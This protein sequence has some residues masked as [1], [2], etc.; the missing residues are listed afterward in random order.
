MIDSFPGLDTSRPITQSDID[1]GF[2]SYEG[3]LIENFF[4]IAD[5]E[6]RDVPFILNAEQ[7]ELDYKV[8][9]RRKKGLPIKMFIPKARR[10][11]ISAYVSARFTAKALTQRNIDGAVV[12]HRQKETNKLFAKVDYYVRNFRGAKPKLGTDSTV[13]ISFPET[14][15]SL[16][17]FTA[18]SK[19]VAR[20]LDC[21]HLHL[22]EAAFYENPKSL[23]ASLVQTI[24]GTGEIFV[25]STGN[26]QGTWY[27]RRCTRAWEGKSEY[28]IV[29][30]PWHQTSDCQVSLTEEQAK[31]LKADLPN[32]EFGEAELLKMF[33]D[34]PLE[35]IQ[36][37]RNKI[38]EF[39]FDI[40][41]FKQEYPMIFEECFIPT[42]RS[43]FHKYT[44]LPTLE[45]ELIEPGLHI[46]RGHPHA[47]YHYGLG[48]DV[49]AG[50]GED[51]SVIQIICLETG[52]QVLEWVKDDVPPDELA[53]YVA[54]FG[55]MFHWPV[56]VVESNNHGI[57]TIDHLMRDRDENKERIYKP[58][59]IYRDDVTSK[60]IVGGGFRTM[61]NTKP[62]WLGKLRRVLAQG[63]LVIFSVELSGEMGTFTS[64]LKAAEGSYD[65]R[66]MALCMA[67]I[68]VTE[69]YK[70]VGKEKPGVPA[71]DPVDDP[72]SFGNVFGDLTS[73][74]QPL[75]SQT[76]EDYP[77]F[78]N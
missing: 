50:V 60:G 44:R 17:V 46:L 65:D 66:V 38:E 23:V 6:Q 24:P 71:P 41:L 27:H 42:S 69:M 68:A 47:T 33:P 9:Q 8:A 48:V 75:A 40:W 49:A 12:A 31:A 10:R 37:R 63:E 20:G 57:V 51:R 36:W 28:G 59:R 30:F 58:G 62:L 15:S 26:G 72:F 11:G 4:M 78:W 64:D 77:I 19:E 34:L 54:E 3:F 5:R 1:S 22:S 16:G 29:F 39:D 73:E 52:E 2:A 74:G 53:Q 14:N 61:K 45:W 55:K 35:R 43:F 25:E 56:C 13:E 76:I 7:R 67:H 21:N 18:G 32:H 70:Y